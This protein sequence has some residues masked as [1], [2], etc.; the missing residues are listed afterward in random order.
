MYASKLTQ[1][2]QWNLDRKKIYLDKFIRFIAQ[3][4][5]SSLASKYVGQPFAIS[6]IKINHSDHLVAN[7][8]AAYLLELMSRADWE[9]SRVIAK[10]FSSIPRKSFIEYTIWLSSQS[11]S[12]S[13]ACKCSHWTQDFLTLPTNPLNPCLSTHCSVPLFFFVPSVKALKSTIHA[14]DCKLHITKD[15]LSPIFP[16][17]V[18]LNKC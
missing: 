13:G 11:L 15:L 10:L 9:V 2:S 4:R 7:N 12:A 18:W 1:L 5:K 14:W 8:W 6:A 17:L 3:V 16:S